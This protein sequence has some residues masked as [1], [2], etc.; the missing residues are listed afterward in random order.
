[1]S[2]KAPPPSLRPADLLLYRNTWSLVGFAIRVKTW[3]DVNHVEVY[4]AMGRWS[5]RARPGRGSTR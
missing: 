4:P 3:S 2:E 1:M 5:P